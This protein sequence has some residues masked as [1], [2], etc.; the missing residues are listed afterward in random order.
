[1]RAF[2]FMFKKTLKPAILITL[3]LTLL[4]GIFLVYKAR[5]EFVFSQSY[6]QLFSELERETAYDK[7]VEK[8]AGYQKAQDDLAKRVNDYITKNSS[9]GKP[10]PILPDGLA[11][12]VVRNAQSGESTDSNDSEIYPLMLT[13]LKDSN[14]SGKLISDKLLAFGRNARRGVTDEYSLSLSAVLTEDY[15]EVLRVQER[16]SGLYDTRAAN[17]F[18]GYAEQD[19]IMY[20]LCFLLFF[21][22]FSSELQSRRLSAFA[23]TKAGAGRF[24]V[25]KLFAN[26]L[27]CVIAFGVYFLSL[28]AIMCAVGGGECL[29]MPLQYLRG[30]ELSSF[31]MTFAGS[32]LS[33]F[34]L[35]LLNMLLLSS[36][37]MLL[38]FVCRKN[39]I[40][41]L[42]CLLPTALFIGLQ[43]ADSLF[44][45]AVCCK[46]SYLL[47][48]EGYVNIFSTPFPIWLLYVLLSSLAVVLVMITV[49]AVALRRY[50]L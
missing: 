26:I 22:T 39:I 5:E 40:S 6:T 31:D 17:A 23:L 45:G 1:M 2:C 20:A 13:N 3:A 15:S 47:G 28:F 16:E 9:F 36:V 8:A 25:Y 50:F 7:T 24:I 38:S 27:T 48:G 32:C 12:A 30:Y 14:E 11:A 29:S 42:V 34:L 4:S 35:R 37:I 49:Y 43:S 41:G 44:A 21:S 18:A 10:P 46:P 19:K 33:V